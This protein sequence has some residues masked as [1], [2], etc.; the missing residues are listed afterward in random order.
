MSENDKFDV[1]ILENVKEKNSGDKTEV[2]PEISNN[3]VE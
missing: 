3:E 1:A 2:I